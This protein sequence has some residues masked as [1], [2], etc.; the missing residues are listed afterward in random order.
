M[1]EGR[2]EGH[3]IA[4]GA[5]HLVDLDLAEGAGA[6]RD[7]DLLV[8]GPIHFRLQGYLGVI[9]ESSFCEERPDA[10]A[11]FAVYVHETHS[12]D[13]GAGRDGEH[14]VSHVG[15]GDCV[16]LVAVQHDLGVL[17]EGFGLRPQLPDASVDPDVR[18][19]Q[20]EVLSV[21]HEHAVDEQHL[22]LGRAHVQ[23]HTLTVWY[24]DEVV[25]CRLLEVFPCVDIRP[26]VEVAE[27]NRLGVFHHGIAPTRHL[28]VHREG[29]HGG[30]VPSPG[31]A[32][33]L[34]L[35]GGRHFALDAV[36]LDDPFGWFGARVEPSALDAHGI[37]SKRRAVLGIVGLLADAA[38]ERRVGPAVGDHI[39][40]VGDRVGR[41]GWLGDEGGLRL[42]LHVGG[43]LTAGSRGDH[44][45]TLKLDVVD[46]AAV[47]CTPV[48][49]VSGGDGGAQLVCL[50][51]L[52]LAGGELVP[53]FVWPCVSEPHEGRPGAAVVGP[54]ELAQLEEVALVMR[55]GREEGQV[56]QVALDLLAHI[57]ANIASV[58]RVRAMVD[59]AGRLRVVVED[60]ALVVLLVGRLVERAQGGFVG[61]DLQRQH[62]IAIR[63]LTDVRL[64]EDWRGAA[65]GLSIH[66]AVLDCT[67]E[68]ADGDA[69]VVGN[70][71]EASAGERDELAAGNGPW[72]AAVRCHAGH[73]E[74]KCD[75]E[76]GGQTLAADVHLNPMGACRRITQSA[77][78]G[79]GVG[80][81]PIGDSAL[82]AADDDLPLVGLGDLLG[83]IVCQAARVCH[84]G[85]LDVLLLEEGL[86]CVVGAHALDLQ[87]LALLEAALD[88]NLVVVD[89][90]VI[91]ILEH[92]GRDA[93]VDVRHLA[94]A[95]RLAL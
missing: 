70:V 33:P 17:L 45:V 3:D 85:G 15:H 42:D 12:A 75:L 10:L 40:G 49:E 36:E 13:S 24:D 76:G 61:E 74:F 43:A 65:G 72:T 67:G 47:C 16:E 91:A 80:R 26:P 7:E 31:C 95:P 93:R 82:L 87:R 14:L 4:S 2:L 30:C 52:E 50:L 28:D 48:A 35:S 22:Q 81:L 20:F 60:A 41:S 89:V 34:R 18:R 55:R 69:V 92:L 66:R 9:L 77:F 29:L 73:C 68:A 46:V 63:Q 27:V 25:F 71:A 64:G 51:D 88:G 37:V 23:Q 44:H 1:L 8:L 59:C 79:G 83:V 5:G 90:R 32:L 86:E 84:E 78:D 39:A 6:R 94:V 53:S 19:F 62:H 56:R 54:L 57:D 38:D 21:P 58:A 11:D